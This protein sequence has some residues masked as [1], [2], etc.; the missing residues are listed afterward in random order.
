LVDFV[1]VHGLGGGSRKTWSKTPSDVHFWPKRW[2]P[3]DPDFA[4]VR[5]WSFGYDSIYAKKK[6]D[7]LN[8]DDFGRALLGALSSSKD[9]RN[10]ETPIVFI[11][12]SMGGLVIK[13]VRQVLQVSCRIGS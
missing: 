11:G 12:H 1:F 7:V 10:V 3:K 9:L 8:I 5:I 2:L 4:N 6:S 13:K